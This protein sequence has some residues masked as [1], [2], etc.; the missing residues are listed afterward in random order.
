METTH[1][2]EIKVAA[3]KNKTFIIAALHVHPTLTSH[4]GT[5]QLH[6]DKNYSK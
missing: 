4:I 6:S 5:L 1:K 2:Q 3:G